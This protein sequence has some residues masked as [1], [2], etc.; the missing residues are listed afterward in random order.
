MAKIQ[1][2]TVEMKSQAQVIVL[3]ASFVAKA[4]RAKFALQDARQCMVHT[5]K[6]CCEPVVKFLDELVGAMLDEEDDQPEYV[7]NKGEE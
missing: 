4:I 6:D 1:I 5:A 3:D 7:P 2:S